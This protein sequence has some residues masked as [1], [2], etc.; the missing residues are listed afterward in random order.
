M[1]PVFFWIWLAVL[2]NPQVN[3]SHSEGD[4][5][6]AVSG[7]LQL[8]VLFKEHANT[9]GCF[10]WGGGNLLSAT[11]RKMLF[12]PNQSISHESWLQSAV[13]L[14]NNGFVQLGVKL[15]FS[16]NWD[17]YQCVCTSST[18]IQKFY[19]LQCWS[20]RQQVNIL[21]LGRLSPAHASLCWCYIAIPIKCSR[22]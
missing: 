15:I 21:T 3:W 2:L 13:S 11:F 19:H 14:F 7:R 20:F 8:S 16:V 6:H 17:S 10:G 18:D 22:F 12:A 1:S 9:S 5:F 4:S